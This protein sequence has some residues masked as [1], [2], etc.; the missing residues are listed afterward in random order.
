MGIYVYKI[1]SPSKVKRARIAGSVTTDRVVC[2][3][4][5]YKPYW[6]DL[7]AN[8]EMYRRIIAPT[9]RAWDRAGDNTPMFVVVTDDSGKFEDGDEVRTWPRGWVCCDDTPDFAGEKI[10]VIRKFGREWVIMPT[11]GKSDITKVIAERRRE[12]AAREAAP[13]ANSYL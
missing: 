7:D 4:Y 11:V 2:L 3:H 10:G 8:A 1:G 12:D 9:E 6:S 13:E 5:A